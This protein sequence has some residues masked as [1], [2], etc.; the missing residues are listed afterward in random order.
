MSEKNLIW[1]AFAW[2]LSIISLFIILL[3]TGLVSLI[4]GDW[5]IWKTQNEI[6]AWGVGFFIFLGFLSSMG[7]A[8]G[9]WMWLRDP[10]EVVKSEDT[11][12]KILA[13]IT[14]SERE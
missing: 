4:V 3:C 8:I 12:T 7:T 6:L 14:T 9:A 1:R 13:D 5:I 11:M 2:T 10:P